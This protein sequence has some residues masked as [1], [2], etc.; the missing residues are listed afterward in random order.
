MY[1][2]AILIGRLGTDPEPRTSKGGKRFLRLNLAVNS[3]GKGGEK[4]TEWFSVF[5]WEGTAE[6]VERFCQK[7]TLIYVE[8][9]IQ[10]S[11][12][13]DAAGTK[14]RTANFNA[15]KVFFLSGAKD[16]SV[17]TKS[18]EFDFPF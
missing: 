1:A 7:G 2:K 15:T 13:T 14:Q 18:T 3:H 5:A 12:W 16:Q 8:A 17:E 10:N 9:G 4:Q 6:L 11:E